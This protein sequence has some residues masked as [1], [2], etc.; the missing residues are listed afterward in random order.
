MAQL[1]LQVLKLIQVYQKAQANLIQII[2]EKEAR[3]NFT[4]YQKDLLQQIN[5]E[6]DRLNKFSIKWTNEVIP[7]EY[8]KTVDET[9]KYFTDNGI[10]IPAED[11]F[12]LLHKR[13]IDILVMNTIEDFTDATNFVGRQ[14]KDVVRQVGLDV[15]TNKIA[16]GGTSRDAKKQLISRL[17]DEG[18]TAIKDKRGR[19][20][21]LDAY[22]Q[23]VARS[24]TAEVTNRATMNQMSN[25]GYDTVKMTEHATTCAICAAL[26]GRVYSISGKD[27]RFPKLSTAF[28]GIYANVHN[29]CRHRIYP[30]VPE[31][32]DDLE[33]DIVK[34]NK[35]FNIDTRSKAQIDAYNQQQKERQQLRNNKRQWERYKFAL[36][37]DTPKTLSGFVR[38]KSANSE[39]YQQLQTDYR[40]VRQVDVEE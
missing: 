23:T 19:N 18:F 20:I 36:P 35:S 39:R 1:P 14:V 15:I 4:N 8:Y 13:A 27:K 28:S 32:A 40:K 2:T 26:Q 34:S 3:G 22:A 24:T 5:D 25:L 10:N 16:T 29:N 6:L 38:M 9:N 12:A 33:G 11:N 17:T 37:D 7:Q 31:L 30:Y 21:S